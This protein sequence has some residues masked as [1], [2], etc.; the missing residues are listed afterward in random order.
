MQIVEL[1]YQNNKASMIIFL[2]KADIKINNNT[3]NYSYLQQISK[4]FNNKLVNIGLPRFKLE[5]NYELSDGLKK[6]GMKSA[7]TPEGDFSGISGTEKLYIDKILHK[8]KLDVSEKGTEA[9]SV[10]AVISMRSTKIAQDP[11]E[12]KVN[13]PFYFIIRENQNKLILFMGYVANPG[14]N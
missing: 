4:S 2:P 7:F 13:R 10:T 6:M 11:I 3:F 5:T 12:F 1:P 9:S 8:S 14:Q